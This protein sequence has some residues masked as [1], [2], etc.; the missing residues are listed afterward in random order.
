[1]QF[2]ADIWVAEQRYTGEH[3]LGAIELSGTDYEITALLD[4]IC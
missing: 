1:M 4:S 3:T 2:A